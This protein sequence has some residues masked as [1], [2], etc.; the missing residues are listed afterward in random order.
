MISELF[1]YHIL[2]SNNIRLFKNLKSYYSSS[3]VNLIMSI[4]KLLKLLITKIFTIEYYYDI[5]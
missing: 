2:I 3:K 4:N 5:I 1:S